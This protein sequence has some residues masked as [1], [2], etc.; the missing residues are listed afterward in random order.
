MRGRKGESDLKSRGVNPV[1]FPG[2]W[3][4]LGTGTGVP[5]F[6]FLGNQNRNRHPGFTGVPVTSRFRL[7]AGSGCTR[8]GNRFFLNITFLE[9]KNSG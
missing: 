6:L 7:P 3:P 8:S 4:K 2:F 5:R 9:K 1:W